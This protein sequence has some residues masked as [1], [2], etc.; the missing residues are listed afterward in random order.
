MA[1]FK[2][3]VLLMPNGP[4]RITQSPVDVSAYESDKKIEDKELLVSYHVMTH[5]KG[6]QMFFILIA[7]YDM[8]DNAS[9][10]QSLHPNLFCPHTV[11]FTA[12]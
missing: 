6:D 7:T 2:F 10:S 4:L 1:Q 8:V 3:T 9:F 11:S 12:L 5:L